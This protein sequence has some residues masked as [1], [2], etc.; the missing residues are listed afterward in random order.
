M[1][2]EEYEPIIYYADGAADRFLRRL[3]EFLTRKRYPERPK[4]FDTITVPHFAQPT[5]SMLTKNTELTRIVDNKEKAE[6]VVYQLM[7]HSESHKQQLK[8]MGIK[9]FYKINM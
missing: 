5:A 3:Y 9:Q 2:K 8:T 7:M 6:R 4:K 1:K